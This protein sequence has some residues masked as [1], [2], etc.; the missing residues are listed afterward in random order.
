MKPDENVRRI[1][2]GLSPQDFLKVGLDQIAYIRPVDDG[3][4]IHG[5]YSI[6]AADGSEI[7][8]LETMDLAIAAI[9]HNDLHPVTLH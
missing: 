5:G 2:E 7:V 4:D 3:P 1:L 8:R 9:R 6:H